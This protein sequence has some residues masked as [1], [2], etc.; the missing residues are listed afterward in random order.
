MALAQ[1][2]ERADRRHIAVG[3]HV[4][5]RK[6]S[7]VVIQSGRVAR[8]QHADLA[9]RLRRCLVLQR[10][11]VHPAEQIVVSRHAHDTQMRRISGVLVVDFH[12]PVKRQ[13]IVHFQ[14]EI[15]CSRRCAGLEHRHHRSV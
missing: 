7:T 6:L 15:H 1:N 2:R 3:I 5:D 14:R 10:Q 11:A 12:I 4:V 9:A 13:V 8:G